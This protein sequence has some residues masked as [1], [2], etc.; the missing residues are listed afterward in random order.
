MSAKRFRIAFSFAGEKRD[1]VAEVA[2][3]LATQFGE[4]AILYDK[5]HQPEFSR[6]DL[7]F[8]LPDLYEK[9][10]D[11]VVA[12]FCPDYENKEWCGLEWNAI[13]GLLKARKVGEVM[14]TRFGRIEGRGLRGLAGYTDLDDLTPRQAADGILERLA[15][16]EGKP[17]EHYKSSAPAVPPAE[18]IPT[19]TT[20]NLP[21]LASFFGRQQEL[22]SIAK[23]LL[24]Q[25]RTWGA[26]IDGP[27]GMGKTSLAVRAAEIAAPQFDRI[28]FVSTK[29]QKLTPDGAVALSNSIVPAYPAML[30]EIARLLA[31]PHIKDKSESELARL[32]K[33][34]VQSEKVLLILDNLENLDKPQ[35][36]LLFEFVSDIP[37]GCKAIVTSRRRTDVDARIIRLGKLDQDAALAYLEELSAGR[38]LLVKA[39]TADRLHLYEETGGNP[40]L[41]RWV[42]GQLGRGGCR[43]IAGALALCRKA[44]AANDPLEFVFGDLLETFTE[45]ETKALAA[46]TYFSQK[47]AVKFIAE[48]ASLSPTA[49]QTALGDL[50]NRALVIPDEADETFALVPMVADFLRAKRPEMVAETGDRLEKRA[51]ALIIEN[52]YSKHDRFPALE[53]AWP[54]IAPA[55]PLF[56]A[57][58]NARLQTVCDALRTLFEFQGRWDEWLALCE[59]A[60]ARAVAA[61]DHDKAGWRAFDIGY[62]HYLRQQADAVLTCADRAAAH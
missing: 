12:V 8:Y 57:G 26:L 5:Y 39:S 43:S 49:A 23:A 28:L 16:N 58:D 36:N 30:N 20:N 56:L 25:T 53:A 54:S 34:A 11:L 15:L 1:F 29:V 35:Q 33:A 45:A 22:D 13:Y 62:I 4:A 7:A 3:I 60:E 40:L 32:I 9:E 55:L 10:A 38:D 41:L 61:A 27:G 21:R 18:P 47:T 50:A 44:F 19:P 14:L 48:L 42:V 24:P 37:S 6:S 17:K 59:K 2:A 52:G 46:L 31:L 51:Y